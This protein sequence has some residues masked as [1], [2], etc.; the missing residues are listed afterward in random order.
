MQDFVDTF[1]PAGFKA[2]SFLPSYGL[3]EA[4]L[5]VSAMLPGQGNRRRAVEE[6][7][8]A[9]G[10]G[11]RR[12]AATLPRGGGCGR[13]VRGM[14]VGIR[15]DDGA[16]LG[17]RERPGPSACRQLIMVGHVSRRRGDRRCLGC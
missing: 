5:A 10:A 16:P 11:E 8:A 2:S 7:L 1:A 17:E 14:E 6:M 4:T 9:A 12:P 3:A 15:S 13:P